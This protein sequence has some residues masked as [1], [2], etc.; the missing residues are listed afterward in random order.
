MH[1]ISKVEAVS[2]SRDASRTSRF[3]KESGV[4]NFVNMCM[5]IC[6]AMLWKLPV[7]LEKD[8]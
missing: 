7:G 4:W 1:S 2:Q 5:W 6:E 8:H 3:S